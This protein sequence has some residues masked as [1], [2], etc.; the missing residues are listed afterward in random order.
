VRNAGTSVVETSG[1]GTSDR[2]AVSVDYTLGAGVEVELF[3]TTSLA[4]TSALG[5]TGNELVQR[6]T[7]NTG[8]NQIDGKDGSDTLLGHGG[9]DTFGFSTTLGVGNVDTIL[10]FNVSDDTV[11]LDDAIF[12]ALAVGMLAANAFST[13]ATGL[14][15]DADDR[16]I[17]DTSNGNLFYDADGTGAGA[18]IQFADLTAGLGLTNNDFD[19]V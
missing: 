16:I 15:Q 3:N 12:T 1:Q 19:V 8:N 6:I 5:L 10:D 13:N 18:S 11:A 17:Y 7:G 14:A 9:M 2:V 4:A